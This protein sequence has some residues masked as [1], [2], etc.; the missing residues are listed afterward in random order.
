VHRDAL[1]EGSRVLLVDDL[2]AT[3]GTAAAGVALRRRPGAEVA[4][5]A[6][7]IDL[8]DLGGRDVLEGMGME[9]CALCSFGGK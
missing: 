5:C 6:F 4:G 8:P 1:P 2:P 7:V 3:G 9:V